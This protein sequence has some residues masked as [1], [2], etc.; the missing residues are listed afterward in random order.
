MSQFLKTISKS[1]RYEDHLLTS[2]KTSSSTNPFQRSFISIKPIL[3]VNESTKGGYWPLQSTMIG[4]QFSWGWRAKEPPRTDESPCIFRSYT[5]WWPMMVDTCLVC[6]PRSW[7]TRQ[8][9]FGGMK[10]Y[11]HF[12]ILFFIGSCTLYHLLVAGIIAAALEIQH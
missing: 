11:L 4:H 10:S 12:Y 2:T 6:P 1:W 8:Q 7:A 5:C 3:I 9:F